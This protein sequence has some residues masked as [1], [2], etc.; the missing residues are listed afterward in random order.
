M[1]QR[2]TSLN[3]QDDRPEPARRGSGRAVTLL[4]ALLIVL[5]AAL[6][7]GGYEVMRRNQALE[8]QVA[9]LA[10]ESRQA[11]DQARQALERAV[12]A[13]GSARAAAEGRL[14]A[15]EKTAG[16]LQEADTARQDADAARQEATSAKETA[17]KAQAEAERIRQQAEKE[18]RRLEEA[19]SQVAE[20]RRTALGVVMNLGSDYLKFE[21]D[22]AEL[23]PEDRELL[24]RIAGILLTSQDYTVSVNGHTDDVGTDEYN[25]RL[26]ERRAQA[27][28]DYLVNAGLSAEIVSVTGHGKSL[29]LVKGTT[30]AA[31]AKNRR[32][33][34]GIA[35]SRIRYGRQAN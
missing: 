20:T 11:N 3:L 25:K 33:E 16:A 8:A 5:L 24:S 30:D 29:P 28:R 21:F 7:L 2:S 34:L 10:A 23:R 6:G 17:A 4:L 1:R 32:V 14:V 22:R 27:V 26:S 31:R 19:L 35:S 9:R 18:M 12:A 13:E 15:E